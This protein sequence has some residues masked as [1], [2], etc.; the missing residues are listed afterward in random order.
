MDLVD[1]QSQVYLYAYVTYNYWP[2]QSKDVGFEI[3]GPYQHVVNQSGDFYIPLQTYQVWAKFT[4]TTDQYGVASYTY[5]M[6]WPCSNPDSITGVWKITASVTVADQVITDTMLF[7][8]QRVVYIEEVSTDKYQYNHAQYVKV[9]V[10]Y[11]THSVLCYPAL[12]AIVISDNLT[13]PVGFT[14]YNTTVGGATFCTWKEDTFTVQIQI[15]KWAYAGEAYVKVSVYDKDPTIGGEAL[16]PQFP[17]GPFVEGTD[18]SL[19]TDA[20]E[21]NDYLENHIWDPNGTQI[22]ILPY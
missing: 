14:T 6:P 18:P 3:E 5:R 12:F 19:P 2:V 20:S 11:L 7:Y 4:A 1:P 10:E 22:D 17:N 15:P 16:C 8:Y 13:V 21:P 9:E